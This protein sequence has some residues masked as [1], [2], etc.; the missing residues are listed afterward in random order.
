MSV[1]ANVI[2]AVIKSVVGD[3]VGDGLAKELADISID[4]ISE[5]GIDKI[6]DF[7]SGKKA[8]M[9][10][11]LSKESMRT[12]NIPENT[13]DHVVEEIKDLFKNIE[14]TDE[15]LRQCKFDSMNLSAFLWNEYCGYKGDGYIECESEIKQC[16]FNVAE[17]LIK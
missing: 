11:I 17:V 15:V 14:I 3:K 6:N 16:L 13:I 12:M 4:G 5:N 1:A 8:K 10:H 2:S 7:I 9:E